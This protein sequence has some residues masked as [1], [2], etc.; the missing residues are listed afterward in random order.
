MS[1]E[2]ARKYNNILVD[3]LNEDEDAFS[4][5][6][7]VFVPTP[8]TP[9]NMVLGPYFHGHMLNLFLRLFDRNKNILFARKVSSLARLG[10]TQ[11]YEGLAYIRF[12]K[13]E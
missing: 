11:A 12:E 9:C 5:D 10:L 4:N 1:P 6:F 3:A 13:M 8:A 2:E 7:Y